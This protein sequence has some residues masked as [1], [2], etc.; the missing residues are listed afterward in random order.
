MGTQ[1]SQQKWYKREEADSEIKFAVTAVFEGES[2]YITTERPFF[3]GRGERER[4]KVFLAAEDS[5][6]CLVF[7]KLGESHHPPYH[8]VNFKFPIW[9][10]LGRE[11]EEEPFDISSSDQKFGYCSLRIQPGCLFESVYIIIERKAYKVL[12]QEEANCIKVFLWANRKDVPKCLW[13][14]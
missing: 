10:R 11:S 9:S 13:I 3:V 2:S 7:S 14:R 4:Q 12:V 6:K 1:T 8:E 5:G